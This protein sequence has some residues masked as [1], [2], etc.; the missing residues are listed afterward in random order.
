MK[1]EQERQRCSRLILWRQVIK[2][3]TIAIFDMNLSVISG[4]GADTCANSARC[5]AEPCGGREAE[6]EAGPMAAVSGSHLFRSMI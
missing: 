2:V 4:T 1:T 5:P 6:T 3:G